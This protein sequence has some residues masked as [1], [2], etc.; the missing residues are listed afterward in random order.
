MRI[1]ARSV[2]SYALHL[3]E[4]ATGVALARRAYESTSDV[5]KNSKRNRILSSIIVGI[6]QFSLPATT[7]IMTAE[8]SLNHNSML[9][10][11]TN[12]CGIFA[13]QFIGLG[14]PTIASYASDNNPMVF[15]MTKTATNAA[16]HIA[17]DL[18]RP[19]L[20]RIKGSPILIRV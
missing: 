1:E 18:V 11:M 19:A 3:L 13:D 4:R 6:A 16:M 20:D 10:K 15:L 2:P 7:R 9:W 12:V 14:I 5:F 8:T 17:L